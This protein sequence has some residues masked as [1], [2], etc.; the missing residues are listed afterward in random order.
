[1]T[2][3][4]VLVVARFPIFVSLLCLCCSRGVVVE[5]FVFVS[6]LVLMVVVTLILVVVLVFAVLVVVWPVVLIVFG[7]LLL[8]AV[9]KKYSSSFVRGSFVGVACVVGWRWRRGWC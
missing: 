8:V 2:I 6:G 3:V 9:L 4:V 5:A 7:L 1:M